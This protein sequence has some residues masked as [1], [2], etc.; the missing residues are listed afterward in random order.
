MK[1]IFTLLIAVIGFVANAQIYSENI[2]TIAPSSSPYPTV[3]DYTGYQNGISSGITYSGDADVRISTASTGYSGASGSANVFFT[4][5]VAGKYFMISGIN[6]SSIAASNLEMSF[7]HY[8]SVTGSNNELKVEVSD[9][10]QAIPVWT[11]LSYTRATGTGTSNWTLITPTGTIPSTSNLGIRFTNTVTSSQFRVDD[12]KIYDKTAPVI[13]TSSTLNMNNVIVNE[14]SSTK[15]LSVTGTNL[16]SNPT[17]TITG[18]DA[19]MFNATGTLTTTGGNLNVVFSPTSTG[20][21]S[22]TLTITSG[23]A[24]AN[25]TLTGNALDPVN[26]YGLAVGTPVTGISENFQSYAADV[27]A[28]TGWTN[29]AQD[30]SKLWS[31]KLISALSTNAAQMTAFGGTGNY[32]SLLIS[33]AINID[34]ISKNTVKF[35][36]AG[37]YTNGATLN[38]YLFKLVDGQPMQ[39]NLLKTITTGDAGN[40]VAFNTETLDLTSYSGVGF[41]AFEYLGNSVDL[42][43]TTYYIDNVTITSNLAVNDLNKSKI[44]LVKNTVVKDVLNFGAKA[45]V[46]F[47]NM[48]GQVVK[49]ASVENGTALD[50]SSLAKGVY[51]IKG[52]VNGETVSQ[53]IVKQ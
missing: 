38:V 43:T 35:D 47:V 25:V 31:V 10:T 17:Y 18:T 51:I 42:K 9:L 33:P 26:P 37:I 23:S 28:I 16:P 36:W 8:K 50:I 45:N 11:Q 22:A 1:K 4:N 44:N 12:I 30:I 6:T 39:K 19:S 15:T 21:K 3:A 53:K 34:Q 7:G 14:S 27:T 29:F 49:S 5:S 40:A 41:L 46:Q 32:I 52:N 24:T 2:G 20:A 48:N 13:T